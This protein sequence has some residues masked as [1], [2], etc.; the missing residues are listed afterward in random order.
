MVERD[1]ADD[2]IQLPDHLFDEAVVHAV[3]IHGAVEV[4]QVLEEGLH[5]D[6]LLLREAAAPLPLPRR[7]RPQNGLGGL[8]VQYAC[9]CTRQRELSVSFSH[10]QNETQLSRLRRLTD[11]GLQDGLHI[12]DELVVNLVDQVAQKLLILRQLKIGETLL[13]LLR[14]VVFPAGLQRNGIITGP[15]LSFTPLRSGVKPSTGLPHLRCTASDS[16]SACSRW[17]AR[18]TVPQTPFLSSTKDKRKFN[19]NDADWRLHAAIGYCSRHLDDAFDAA[20]GR[21]E[22]SADPL[23]VVHAVCV[24]HAHEDDVSGKSGDEAGRGAARLQV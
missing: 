3:L 18:K 14:G 7:H 19:Q 20:D 12:F 10:F 23:V 16:A 5:G 8:R 21:V 24:S 4:V 11:D 9:G 22:Q 1:R 6:G 17:P 13:I 2:V 15:F